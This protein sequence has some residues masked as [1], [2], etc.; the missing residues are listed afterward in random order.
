LSGVRATS[1]TLA[2]RGASTVRGPLDEAATPQ[3]VVEAPEA[4]APLEAGPSS[5]GE[6]REAAEEGETG[7]A[8]RAGE[9]GK[10]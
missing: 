3:Q 1:F 7:D 8:G 10:T 6:A 2:G 4:K 5:H 9:G